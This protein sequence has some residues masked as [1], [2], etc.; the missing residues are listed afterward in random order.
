MPMSLVEHHDPLHDRDVRR[1]RANKSAHLIKKF[2]PRTRTIII[3]SLGYNGLSLLE[4]TEHFVILNN[5]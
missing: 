2:Y 5:E 3:H 4:S 1:E